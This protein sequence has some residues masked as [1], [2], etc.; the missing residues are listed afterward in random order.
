MPYALAVQAEG[1]VALLRCA[2]VIERHDT[3]KTLRGWIEYPD[4][5]RRPFDNLEGLIDIAVVDAMKA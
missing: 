4:G 3:F 1:V 5:S 2:E